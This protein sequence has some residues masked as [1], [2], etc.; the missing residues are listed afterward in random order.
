ME[1]I[2]I[3]AT[4]YT[5][6]VYFDPST[7]LIELKGNSNPANSNSFYQKFI[8]ELDEY[9]T[10]ESGGLTANLSFHYFNTSSSKCI[11]NM[12]K[13]LHKMQEAGRC[14]TINW[15]YLEEDEEMREVGEDFSDILRMNFNFITIAA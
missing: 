12:L 3:Q 15:Y 13:K 1:K 10:H 9:V 7:G 4:D 5:P 8:V 2:Y 11:F 6:F 14:V